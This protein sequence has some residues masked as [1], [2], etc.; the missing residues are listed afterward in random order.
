MLRIVWGGVPF[1]L[2]GLLLTSRERPRAAFG[3]VA[4]LGTIP[5]KCCNAAVVK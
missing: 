5:S 4:M 1:F 3:F 2:H